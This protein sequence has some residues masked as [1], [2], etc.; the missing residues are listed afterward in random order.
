MQSPGR[1]P[2]SGGYRLV[3]SLTM[4]LA[5]AGVVLGAPALAVAGI[6][7]VWLGS[8]LTRHLPATGGALGYLSLILGSTFGGPLPQGVVLGD[9]A[10]LGLLGVV[11]IVGSS[12]ANSG[13]LPARL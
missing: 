4:I 7:L 3:A 6:A 12:W 1:W 5:M 8:L 2:R 10:V 13:L 11:A 9:V